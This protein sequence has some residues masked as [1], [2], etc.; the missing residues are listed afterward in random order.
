M[1]C[2]A[3]AIFRTNLK[4]KGVERKSNSSIAEPERERRS[5]V[6]QHKEWR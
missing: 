4:R 1:A 6:F 3:G 5:T 2:R